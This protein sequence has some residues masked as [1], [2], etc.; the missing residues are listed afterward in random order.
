MGHTRLR[1]INQWGAGIGRPRPWLG[2]VP[3]A[4]ILWHRHEVKV[5]PVNQL[6]EIRRKFPWITVTEMPGSHLSLVLE[7]PICAPYVAEA[8]RG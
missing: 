5:I 1:T 7:A 4:T 2:K 6:A 3:P 8:L